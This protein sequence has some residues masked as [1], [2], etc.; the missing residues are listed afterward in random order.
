M[1]SMLQLSGFVDIAFVLLV[2]GICV[3]SLITKLQPNPHE[4][5]WKGE[6]LELEE[7]L[8]KLIED[9]SSAG[10]DLNQNLLLRKSELQSLIERLEK[11]EVEKHPK[12]V[13][14]A[15]AKSPKTD[16]LPN[17][18]WEK[19]RESLRKRDTGETPV[20]RGPANESLRR[21]IEV[22]AQELA[23]L[24]DDLHE[25]EGGFEDVVVN[26]APDAPEDP[27]ESVARRVARRLLLRGQE[28]HVVARKVELPLTEVRKIDQGLRQALEKGRH[29]SN[30]EEQWEMGAAR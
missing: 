29:R 3:R 6:L 18:S 4:E 8:R 7:S 16:D 11:S 28:I 22:S 13:V 20:G 27:S 1:T 25:Q 23:Q 15:H 5:Q 21:Q 12:P 26:N 2:V 30:D 10:R 19:P 17:P 9:A 14:K 24:Q